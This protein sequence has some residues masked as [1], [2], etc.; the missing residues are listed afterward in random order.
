MDIVKMADSVMKKLSRDKYG[1]INL[2]TNQIRKF[3]TAVN[4]LSNKVSVYKADHPGAEKLSEELADEVKYL[5][6]MLVYQ[7]GRDNAQNSK[8][9]SV[10]EFVRESKLRE[11]INKVGDSIYTYEKF[12]RYVEALVAFHKYNGGKDK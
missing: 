11:L 5:E 10:D 4:I 8:I 3:L 2:K 7:V 9:K 12:A 1:N 6:V